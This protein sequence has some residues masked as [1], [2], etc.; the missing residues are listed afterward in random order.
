MIPPAEQTGI[1]STRLEWVDAAK[2]IAILFVLV[3][4]S[5]FWTYANAHSDIELVLGICKFFKLALPPYMAL[6]FVLSGYT[7]K[8]RSGLLQQRFNRLLVPYFIWGLFYLVLTWINLFI[9]G[10]SFLSFAKPAAGLIYSRFSLFPIES[11]FNILLLPSGASPLWFLTSL[12]TSYALLIPIVRFEKYRVYIVV[13]YLVAALILSFSPILLPWSIDVAPIGA[14]FLYAG[15]LMKSKRI[16]ASK[17]SCLV[18]VAFVFFAIYALI[19]K[20]NGGINMSVREYGRHLILSPFLFVFI[21]IAGS[22]LY[23]IVCMVLEK[24]HLA[25]P[26]AYIGR[27]SLTLLCS[28]IFV[29]IALQKI[30]SKYTMHYGIFTSSQYLF[31]LE[32][33]CAVIFAICL[34]ECKKRFLSRK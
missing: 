15:Y 30:F 25:K 18:L 4:H 29:F 12:F 6:F 8:D 27:V 17:L 19:V 11:D 3:S 33:L 13:S 20:Y 28:H 21:G 14:L 7:F 9:N 31:V 26:F 5:R 23:C 1:N 34:T 10:G 32:I 24:V 2:G 22:F 16:F